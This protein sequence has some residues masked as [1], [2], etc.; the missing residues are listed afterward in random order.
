MADKIK[1]LYGSTADINNPSSS[2]YPAVVRGQVYF[3]VDSLTNSATNGQLYFDVP[4]GTGTQAKRILMNNRV[5][6]AT[7]AS[8]ALYASTA[9]IAEKDILNQDITTYIKGISVSGTTLNYT[10]G[11][12]TQ[13]SITLQDQKLQVTSTANV[14]SKIY[15]I[16]NASTSLGTAG[17]SVT[18]TGLVSKDIYIDTDGFLQG[19]I[20]TKGS[21]IFSNDKSFDG[22]NDVN[23]GD[24]IHYLPGTSTAIAITNHSQVT[25]TSTS[26]AESQRVYSTRWGA[27]VDNSITSLYSGLTIAYKIPIA[28]NGTYGNVLRL[29]KADGTA[30][31]NPHNTSANNGYYPVIKSATDWVTTHY[32]VNSI[33]ILV[34]D[35]DQVTTNLKPVNNNAMSITGCW[36]IVDYDTTNT[37]QLRHGSGNYVV[38]TS[39]YRYTLLAEVNDTTLMPFYTSTANNGW[40]E[41][42]KVAITTSFRPFGQI[43]Y[44]SG[45]SVLSANADIGAS[46]LW[47]Q[48]TIDL[49]YSFNIT[50]T[51]LTNK[52]HVY[53]VTSLPSDS[54][55]LVTLDTTTPIVQDLPTTNTNKL[56]I[57]LGH[58]YNGYCIELYPV[59]PVYAFL[60]GRLRAYTDYADYAKI[61]G[62]ATNDAIGQN[63]AGTYIKGINVSG[64]TLSYTF[65]DNG[66]HSITLQDN[67]YRLKVTSTSS[68]SKKIYLFG[69]TAT[70]LGTN[71]K[72][73][74][75][76]GMSHTDIYIDTNGEINGT[77]RNALSASTA[78]RALKDGRGQS[79]ETTYLSTYTI[80]SVNGVPTITFS[81]G[82]GNERPNKIKYAPVGDDGKID[83]T[84]IP[85]TAIER[86]HIVT[87]TA[88]MF[89]LTTATVQKG[90]VVKV[91]NKGTMYFVHD[92]TK[93]DQWAGYVEFAVG[94]AGAVAWSNITGK[95]LEAILSTS[96][97]ASLST[98]TSTATINLSWINLSNDEKVN[99]LV[100]PAAAT[101]VAG[102]VTCS[103]D[104]VQTF[105]GPKTFNSTVNVSGRLNYSGIQTG[106]GATN[107]IWFS[108]S[109]S[110]GIPTYSTDLYYDAANKIL[111]TTVESAQHD[112]VTSTATIAGRYVDYYKTFVSTAN[113][114]I[115]TNGTGSENKFQIQNYYPSS[116]TWAAAANTVTLTIRNRSQQDEAMVSSAVTATIPLANASSAGI[117]S[118]SAQTFGGLKTFKDGIAVTGKF[119]ANN[120][121][122]SAHSLDQNASIFTSGG[123]S[124]E[125]QLSAK[126]I[127]IDDNTA[128]EGVVLQYN[129]G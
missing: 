6:F 11:S 19:N 75:G 38:S 96:S 120:P 111:H 97:S 58:A 44:R 92:D 59:H 107:Y 32:P 40:T 117:V 27:V 49:R 66:Q 7:N 100:I 43:F 128:T 68:N 5:A 113:E 61:A 55:G 71:N 22:S 76:T 57:L 52:K 67:D 34:F 46:E 94:T 12:G 51:S 65:G 85:N 110:K 104:T 28:G 103:T 60:N 88:D 25:N 53:L 3:A 48:Y 73:V 114:L 9:K 112:S 24:T 101:N 36:K 80:T 116:A 118:A 33:I 1:F 17:N 63:I 109:A 129:G 56:Y 79:I 95:P 105:G 98:S 13:R 31:T 122:D 64:T 8:S 84:Y 47:E 82:A 127:R 4:I 15:L 45:S 102:L 16:G 124:V 78:T 115:V 29:T 14:G 72:S 87:S 35:A 42:K 50:T 106:S 26:I 83:L 2:N 93:L 54:T 91:T 125:K 90:D 18:S 39:T 62:A 37:Y 126:Q 74:T 123:I 41:T 30:I 108:S 77:I 20:K 89:A 119:K 69:S 70:D 99:I 21:L 81:D 121:T 86:L 10:L 23:V